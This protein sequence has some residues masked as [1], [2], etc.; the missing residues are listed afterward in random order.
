MSQPKP[1]KP[2][3]E[4]LQRLRNSADFQRY[5]K[6]LQALLDYR[7]DLLVTSAPADVPVI[8][9]RAL[10]LQDLLKLHSKDTP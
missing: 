1:D 7:K 2:L 3:I 8:Q 4:S 9:G 5:A 6:H 10:E